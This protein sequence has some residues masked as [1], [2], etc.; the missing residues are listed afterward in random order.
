[1]A[2]DLKVPKIHLPAIPSSR[3]VR[4]RLQEVE[5]LAKRLG[6]L[7][8]LATELELVDT[9]NQVHPDQTDRVDQSQGGA[10]C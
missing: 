3:V 2:T 9:E 10:K 5:A 6:V 4:E 8:R 7:L 1:M